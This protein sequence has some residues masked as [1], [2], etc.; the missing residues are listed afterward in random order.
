MTDLEERPLWRR[1]G[2]MVLIWLASVLVLAAISLLIRL[3]LH[4]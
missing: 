2:W 1:M 4:A 3:W